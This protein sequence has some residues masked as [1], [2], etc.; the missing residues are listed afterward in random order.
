MRPPDI[1][2]STKEER[3]NYIKEKFRCKSDCES[4]GLCRVFRGKDPEIVYEEYIQGKKD[5]LDISANYR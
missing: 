4:C 5:F 2:K 3:A 1:E